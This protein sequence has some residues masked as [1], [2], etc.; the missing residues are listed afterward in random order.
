MDILQNFNNSTTRIVIIFG[1]DNSS[2]SCS[3]NRKNNFL[4][5]G[6]CRTVGIHRN[7]GSPVK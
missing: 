2:S 5:V 3:D 7:F 1:A 6:E 4:T